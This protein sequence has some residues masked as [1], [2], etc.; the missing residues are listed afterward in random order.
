MRRQTSTTRNAFCFGGT[1]PKSP[2]FSAIP[3]P[4]HPRPSFGKG[5]EGQ[6][7]FHQ[8]DSRHRH[9][10]GR[11]Q[12]HSLEAPALPQRCHEVRD[13]M[14]VQGDPGKG[15]RVAPHGQGIDPALLGDGRRQGLEHL[16]GER[17]AVLE[18]RYDV[19]L[20]LQLGLPGLEFFDLPDLLFQ[21]RDFGGC[22]L[23]VRLER[24]DPVP[25][26]LVKHDEPRQDQHGEQEV[27]EIEVQFPALLP[28]SPDQ[29]YPDHPRSSRFRSA[30]PMATV[31]AVVY[32]ETVAGGTRRSSTVSPSKGLKSSTSTPIFSPIIS[33]RKVDFAAPPVRYSFVTRRSGYVA[34]K[35]L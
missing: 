34:E 18:V 12:L 17:P 33:F 21:P 19:H 32:W 27:Q 11:S 4:R 29:V 25:G 16:D 22:F 23:D 24:L 35:K 13:G 2:S 28:L 3:S 8:L 5:L 9:L 20:L 26:H 1:L 30:S 10:V 7:E 6:I 15:D 31:A 14:V